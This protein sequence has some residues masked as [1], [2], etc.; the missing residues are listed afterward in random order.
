MKNN[1]GFAEVVVV[2]VFASLFG[3]LSTGAIKAKRCEDANP[4]ENFEIL[5]RKTWHGCKSTK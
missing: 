5:D 2:V 1:S 4:G 3:L